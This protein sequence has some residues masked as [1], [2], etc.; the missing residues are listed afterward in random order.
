MTLRHYTAVATCLVSAALGVLAFDR[1]WFSAA[2]AFMAVGGI[3][4]CTASWYGRRF[5]LA[6][7]RRM[8]LPLS[9]IYQEARRGELPATGWFINAINL[10]ATLF[11]VGGFVALFAGK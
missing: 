11:I 3:W 9:E 1:D 6:E 8:Q 10:T 7:W 5:N 4:S 2:A